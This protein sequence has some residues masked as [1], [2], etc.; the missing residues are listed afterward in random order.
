[1]SSPLPGCHTRFQPSPPPGTHRLCRK[2]TAGTSRSW[3]RHRALAQQWDAPGASLELARLGWEAGT[4]VLRK[5][6][7]PAATGEGLG[8]EEWP[9]APSLP[10]KSC[11]SPA[12]GEAL[13]WRWS[14]EP[15]PN[16]LE[17]PA[18]HRSQPLPWNAEPP[19][20]PGR[21]PRQSV[22]CMSCTLTASQP[23]QPPLA[24][25]PLSPGGHRHSRGAPAPYFSAPK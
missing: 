14:R 13:F 3:P 17:S 22:Y 4:R 21:A 12:S 25:H 15:S 10:S 2:A 1:M 9:P 24:W 8:S 23:L 5:V 7:R 6:P 11:G 16:P 18:P 19:P 20:T